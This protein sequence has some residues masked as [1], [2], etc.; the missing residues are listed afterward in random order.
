M[1]GTTNQQKI[2]IIGFHTFLVFEQLLVIKIDIRCVDVIK[3]EII[4]VHLKFSL[5][6]FCSYST[7][8]V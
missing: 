7:N 6:I 2:T 5:K 8:S 4:Q 1:L 3:F